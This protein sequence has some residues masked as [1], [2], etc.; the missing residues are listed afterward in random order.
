MQ[1]VMVLTD[2]ECHDW[3]CGTLVQ[4]IEKRLTCEAS[5]Q[6]Q[7]SDQTSRKLTPAN[8]ITGIRHKVTWKRRHRTWKLDLR[9]PSEDLVTYLE[10]HQLSLTVQSG[11]SEKAFNEARRATFV[12]ACLV[13]NELDNSGRFKIK[14]PSEFAN[15]T[16]TIPSQEGCCKRAAETDDDEGSDDD[17]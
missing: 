12:T 7:D 17:M 10:K 4:E 8:V 16:I 2:K 5:S 6:E 13:W 1:A 9:K 14:L 3:I 15:D 11:L